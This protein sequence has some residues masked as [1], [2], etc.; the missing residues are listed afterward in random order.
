[1]AGFKYQIEK[2]TNRAQFETDKLRRINK[3]RA[4]ADRVRKGI[5]N[6]MAALGQKA[7]ELA[8]AGETLNPPLQEITNRIAKLQAE[9]EGHLQQIEG[10]KAEAW[11]PPPPPPPP[12]PKPPKPVV[13]KPEPK[14]K[15]VEA[16][17][18][19]PKST[20]SQRLMEYINEETNKVECP[21]CRAL[22]PPE[23]NVCRN[24]GYRFRADAV[25]G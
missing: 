5:K 6:E 12:P 20:V 23:E 14:P 24:C 25:D 2:S 15:P 21:R 9:L 18:A 8:V 19:Q 1:M 17:P 10:I 4:V 3:V 11:V 7:L 22:S 16:A 13:P